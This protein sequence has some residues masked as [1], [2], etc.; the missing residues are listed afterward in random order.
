MAINPCVPPRRPVQEPGVRRSTRRAAGN[1]LLVVATT[2]LFCPLPAADAQTDVIFPGAKR[3]GTPETVIQPRPDEQI[4][5]LK[6]AQNDRVIAIFAPALTSDGRPH[7]DPATRPT[8]LYFYGNA[9]CLRDAMDHVEH[10]RR[11]GVNV[12][13]PE[14]VGYGMSGGKPSESGCQATAAAAL[15]YLLRERKDVDPQKIIACGWSLGGA[16]A[17]DL[18][19]REKDKI[20]GLIAL[21]SFTSLSEMA[22]YNVPLSPATILFHHHFDNLQKMPLVKCPVLI[23]HGR[24][25]TVVPCKMSERLIKAAR[26]PVMSFMLDDAGHND[27]FSA[28]GDQVLRA[29]TTFVS[30]FTEQGLANRRPPVD[31]DVHRTSGP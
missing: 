9:M 13:C 15:A 19:V 18:A 27:F 2:I 24:A 4:V 6:T 1:R 30:Q 23:G 12:L 8:L 21:S 22:K 25:D 28:G 31:P 14:Y 5:T 29:M 10:F 17:I 26:V 16:V 3:Q 20:A 11:L 7:P